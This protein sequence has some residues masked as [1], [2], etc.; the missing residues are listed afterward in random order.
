MRQLL[1]AFYRFLNNYIPYFNIY[2]EYSF[3]YYENDFINI[4][5][6]ENKN[7]FVNH[8]EEKIVQSEEMVINPT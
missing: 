4:S 7:T 8:D 5:W 6:L 1:F 2:L 3:C